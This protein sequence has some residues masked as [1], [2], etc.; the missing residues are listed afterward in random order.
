M[1][2]EDRFTEGR[3]PNAADP[4]QVQAASF[5]QDER[6]RS[7]D[8]DLR[9]ILALPSGRRFI[10]TILEAAGVYRTSFDTEALVMAANEGRRN[11]GLW[12]LAA[13]QR[14]DPNAYLLM[15]QERM[16][17]AKADLATHEAAKIHS[18]AS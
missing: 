3:M 15:L 16:A 2:T 6:A 17:Q 7:A 13:I 8:N 4:G 11:Q 10:G 14:I 18:V 1:D 12:L 5:K 9:D